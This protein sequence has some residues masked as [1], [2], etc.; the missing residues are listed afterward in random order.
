MRVLCKLPN[1]SG[2]INGIKFE[3]HKLGRIS[4]EI[5]ED[6]AAHFLK[7]NGYVAV[8]PEKKAAATAETGE[9]AETSDANKPASMTVKDAATA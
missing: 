4:E 1:A 6:I 3:K 7:I 5:D 8:A 2:L 9:G